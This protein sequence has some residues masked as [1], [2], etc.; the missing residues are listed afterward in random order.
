[1]KGKV[2]SSLTLTT[3]TRS[4]TRRTTPTRHPCSTSLLWPAF[5]RNWS[6]QNSKIVFVSGLVEAAGGNSLFPPFSVRALAPTIGTA[7]MWVSSSILLCV[8]KTKKKWKFFSEEEIIHLYWCRRQPFCESS[9]FWEDS[10]QW[11][12]TFSSVFSSL[13]EC[14][15]KWAIEKPC[16]SLVFFCLKVKKRPEKK[17]RQKKPNHFF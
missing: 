17:K 8:T 10:W 11:F 15:K 9:K 16:C 7:W 3:E 1:M 2:L 4:V 13:N 5:W 12:S 14:A 6:L